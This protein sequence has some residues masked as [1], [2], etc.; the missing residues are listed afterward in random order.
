MHF[1]M[2]GL[3]RTIHLN[4]IGD[5]LLTDAGSISLPAR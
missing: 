2:N 3:V 4:P 5:P 1:S